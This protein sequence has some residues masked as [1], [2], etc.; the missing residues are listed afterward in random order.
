MV[1][2]VLHLTHTDVRI[3]SRILKEM[4][5]LATTLHCS[6]TGIGIDRDRDLAA[7]DPGTITLEAIDLIARKLRFVPGPVRQALA[8]L[9]YSARVVFRAARSRPDVVHCHD[10][11]VL[12]VGAVLRLLFGAK[13]IYDTHELESDRNGISPAIGKVILR[14]EKLLWRLVD[15]LVVVSPS[16]EDWYAQ[17]VGPKRTAVVLNSP[18]F[19]PFDDVRGDDY[20]RRTFPIDAD[21][22]AF[23]YVGNLVVGRG[24]EL[25]LDAF[26]REDVDSAVVFMGRGELQGAVEDAAAR[27]HNIFFHEAV[28]H[29]E[30][31]AVTRSA[32]VGLCLIENVSLSDYHCLPNKLF[33]YCF[34]GIPVLASDF[35]DI[36]ATVEQYRL[37]ICCALDADEI[38]RGIGA[39]ERGEVSAD[40]ADLTR[41]GWLAQADELCRL[42]RDIVT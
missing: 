36:A 1:L 24:V 2:N 13:L 3:D 26:Q 14:L 41:L 5:S 29:E 8:M 6:V 12:P 35:P 33:E 39:F 16:I 9:E 27:S 42:Y 25:V 22:K 17:H 37:G 30:V 15:G 10:T 4:N 40:F 20:L 23:I 11:G 21:S 28:P 32:D 31:V 38:H 19:A 34:A 18:V 7:N